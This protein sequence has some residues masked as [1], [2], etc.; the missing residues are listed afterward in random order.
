M[1]R[2]TYFS[3]YLSVYPL[4][5]HL[6]TFPYLSIC[7]LLHFPTCL[8]LCVVFE[9]SICFLLH[10]RQTPTPQSPQEQK[11]FSP[12]VVGNVSHSFLSVIKLV[13]IFVDTS[14]KFR[15][16]TQM[17]SK[18]FFSI[19]SRDIIGGGKQELKKTIFLYKTSNKLI[20][21]ISE[22]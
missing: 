20:L 11:Y 3:T 8:S 19:N 21:Y 2:T 9:V 13:D 1:E 15:K 17:F 4:T 16:I 18:F 7:V 5:F 10:I 12:T 6:S 14:P 22:R